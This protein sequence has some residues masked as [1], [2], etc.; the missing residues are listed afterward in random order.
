MATEKQIDE[1]LARLKE[2]HPARTFKE[3]DEINAGIGAV[4]CL[5]YESSGLLTAGK[6]SDFMKVSTARVTVLLKKM[7]AKGLITIENDAADS[8]ITI[9]R[10][11]AS[12]KAMIDKINREMRKKTEKV[13]DTIG[14][15]KMRE[16][17]SLSEQIQSIMGKP[18]KKF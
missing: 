11:S 10:L 12:G 15:D 13:I 3:V 2:I 5:L 17:I 16:F 9:V 4:L 14:M 8:R 18:E 6:I 1:I 7:T